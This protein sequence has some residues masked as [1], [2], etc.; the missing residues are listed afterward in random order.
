MVVDRESLYRTL[1]K[2]REIEQD[3]RINLS[4]IEV[5]AGQ[6]EKIVNSGSL[7]LDKR[8]FIKHTLAIL[9]KKM[10]D[11]LAGDEVLTESEMFARVRDEI[12]RWFNYLGS[13]M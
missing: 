10:E 6:I 7:R 2:L 13:V 8:R 12:T 3:T 11:A 5:L 1:R 4:N 9:K